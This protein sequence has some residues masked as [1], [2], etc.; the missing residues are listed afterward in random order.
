[1]KTF[2]IGGM[3][4]WR[5]LA[6]P[7]PHDVKAAHHFHSMPH[8]QQRQAINRLAAAGHTDDVIARATGLHVDYVRRLLAEVKTSA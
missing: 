1:M 2:N 8:D 6:A 3:L 4:D 7:L 5:A